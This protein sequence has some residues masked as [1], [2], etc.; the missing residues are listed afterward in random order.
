MNYFFQE[1]PYINALIFSGIVIIT[2]FLM[3]LGSYLLGPRRT[4]KQKN[5]PY[6]CGVD[7]LDKEQKKFNIK[8]YL[9]AALFILFDVEIVFIVPWAL[10]YKDMVLSGFG[11]FLM[12]DMFV[13]IFILAIGI[14]YILKKG[15]L[16]WD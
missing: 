15:A 12:I 10:I 5:I 14:L 2:A 6:E 1:F 16:K 9:I 4:S 3:I 13:F 11:I 8:F 7:P